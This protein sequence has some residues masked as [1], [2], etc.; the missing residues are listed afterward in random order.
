MENRR[1]QLLAQTETIP[2]TSQISKLQ[3]RSKQLRLEDIEFVKA[4]GRIEGEIVFIERSIRQFPLK[5]SVTIP[6]RHVLALP[7]KGVAQFVL[8]GLTLNR[9]ALIPT[10]LENQSLVRLAEHLLRKYSGSVMSLYAYTNDV[11]LYANRLEESPDGIIKDA[12]RS[13]A[14]IKVHCGFLDTQIAE[15]Q[16]NGRTSGRLWGFQKHV[17]SWYRVSGLDIHASLLPAPHVTHQDRVPAQ[18]ELQALLAHA[19]LR[20]KAALALLCFSGMREGTL[21]KLTYGHIRDDYEAGRLPLHIKI[22]SHLLKGK[23]VPSCDT[24]L[25]AEAVSHV[26]NYMEAR[27][28]GGVLYKTM[29]PEQITDASPLIRDEMHYKLSN[30]ARPIGEK[31]IYK[32][33]HELFIKSGV[34][35]PDQEHYE[36][37]VH[38]LRKWFK[39]SIM[40]AGISEAYPDY[41]MAHKRDV[42][43]Q[44]QSKGIDHLR[45][46]YDSA[47]L[48]I[49]PRA[50]Q[51]KYERAAELLQDLFPGE[52]AR[53]YLA[54]NAFAEPHRIVVGADAEDHQAAVIMARIKDRLKDEI[55]RD[56]LNPPSSA[57]M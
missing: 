31:Q 24:F 39:T 5:T 50:A 41:M 19:D 12:K 51:T 13:A 56:L 48:C 3:L 26:H 54:A 37:K 38:T 8:Q 15:L 30:R 29:G 2:R 34:M 57:H 16:D 44:L 52:D 14:R 28:R 25:T 40:Q 55:R 27:R 7:S 42:Y 21:A 22:E 45:T 4:L 53:K 43:T 11:V 10:V 33:L 17:R 47:K 49:Q 20:E 35:K 18:Q 32:I 1:R 36:L 6:L 23:Y 46:V 9:P